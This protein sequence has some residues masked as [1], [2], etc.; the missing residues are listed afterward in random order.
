M[1]R[2][3]Y[4]FEDTGVMVGDRIF[5]EKRVGSFGVTQEIAARTMGSTEE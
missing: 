4:T 2:N 3:R 5:I 1:A